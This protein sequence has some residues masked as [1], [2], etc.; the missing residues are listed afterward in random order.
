MRPATRSLKPATVLPSLP[1][2]DGQQERQV[3]KRHAPHEGHRHLVRRDEQRD[4]HAHVEREHE[5]TVHR[6]G[7]RER[8]GARGRVLRLLHWHGKV[9]P[10]VERAVHRFLVDNDRVNRG[11]RVGTLHAGGVNRSEVGGC[12]GYARGVSGSI[13]MFVLGTERT[14]VSGFEVALEALLL[15]AGATR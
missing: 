8:T 13:D 15:R 5:R 1:T 3:P 7:G 2:D 4:G 14:E 11:N 6:E 12:K 9:K 10:G